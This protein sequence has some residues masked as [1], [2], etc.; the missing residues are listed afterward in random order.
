VVAAVGAA[1]GLIGFISFLSGNARR[2]RLIYEFTASARELSAD[3]Q[4]HSPDERDQRR[5]VGPLISYER[6]L[7]RLGAYEQALLV[8]RLIEQNG[9]RSPYEEDGRAWPFA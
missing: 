3:L 8:S 9:G 1:I 5:E 4:Q 2:R 6:A 7:L